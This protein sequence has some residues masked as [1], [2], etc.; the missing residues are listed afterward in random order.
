MSNFKLELPEIEFGSEL[1][2]VIIE[3]EHLRKD[4]IQ[5]TTPPFFFFQLKRI[6][7]I[8][9]SVGSA[10][11]EGNRTTVSD[12][13]NAINAGISIDSN[14]NL[15][16]VSNLN[17]ALD[18]V[19]LSIQKDSTI[20]EFFIREL[21][22]I[23]V[24]GLSNEGDRGAGKYRDHMVFIS[25]S[26]HMP[27]E[28]LVVPDLMRDL[29]NFI[30]REDKSQFDLIKVAL[31]HHSFGWIHPFGNGNGRT[32]RL[33]TYAM[34]LKY[35]FNVGDYGRLINPT[36]IFCCNRDKYYE[37]LTCADSGTKQGIYDW[38]LYV[39]KGLLIE[40]KKLDVLL[41]YDS[42]KDK[43]LIPS[44]DRALKASQISSEIYDVLNLA[45]KKGFLETKD[46]ISAFNM[47]PNKASYMIKTMKENNLII[48]KEKGKRSYILNLFATPI[49]MGIVNSLEQLDLIPKSLNRN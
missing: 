33:L 31:V 18:Y 41:Q 11:I 9:E 2:S 19:D 10:R 1:A 29:V 24:A 16:E 47:K 17:K 14:E 35:G 42:V 20:T 23:V 26:A 38:C 40:R 13:T 15:L 27:P 7:H 8:L 28:P 43:I 39:L 4:T 3:L 46:I 34:L 22:Q 6:F 44:I 48:P 49:I 37:M 12:Y 32:V 45:V 21:Q 5:G 36:A 25:G 30:N